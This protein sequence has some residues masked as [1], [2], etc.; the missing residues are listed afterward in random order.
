MPLH[1]KD[2]AHPTRLKKFS[3]TASRV[4]RS[5]TETHHTV[6]KWW[7]STSF[8]PYIYFKLIWE[9]DVLRFYLFACQLLVPLHPTDVVHPTWLHL[10][11]LL[12]Y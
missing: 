3:I 7:V 6:G 4:G 10:L 1:Q 5:E 11:L 12:R 9:R 8:L 2:V